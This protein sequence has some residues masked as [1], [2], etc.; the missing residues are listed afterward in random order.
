MIHG[1]LMR[2]VWFRLTPWPR[3]HVAS[4]SLCDNGNEIKWLGSCRWM[5]DGLDS[6]FSNQQVAVLNHATSP[7]SNS[8]VLGD[9]TKTWASS[10]WEDWY[11]CSICSVCLLVTWKYKKV[12][13]WQ[14]R[15]PES[16]MQCRC[17]PSWLQIP[18]SCFSGSLFEIHCKCIYV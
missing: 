7:L 2:I 14:G 3:K 18:D 6:T 11:G 15:H 12:Y 10:L 13:G 1:S 4:T 16:R 8:P 9:Q 17:Y 5:R